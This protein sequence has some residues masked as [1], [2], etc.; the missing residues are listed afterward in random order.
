MNNP[1]AILRRVEINDKMN[2]IRMTEIV[3]L[4][5]KWIEQTPPTI[6]IEAGRTSQ[7]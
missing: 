5:G 7:D 2:L 1:D 3:N 4:S 6:V